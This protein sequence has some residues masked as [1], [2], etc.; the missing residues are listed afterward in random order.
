MRHGESES[1]CRMKRRIFTIISGLSLVL[2]VTAAALWAA[3]RWHDLSICHV[4]KRFVAG[5]AAS[6]GRAV[7]EVVW[8]WDVPWGAPPGWHVQSRPP[9][10]SNLFDTIFGSQHAFAGFGLYYVHDNSYDVHV[11]AFTVPFWAIVPLMLVLPAF[12]FRKRRRRAKRGFEVVMSPTASPD[13]ALANE[14]RQ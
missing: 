10:P 1:G 3:S 11:V 7:I 12:W 13:S 4:G 9:P 8:I 2:C 6:Q 14:R 5:F